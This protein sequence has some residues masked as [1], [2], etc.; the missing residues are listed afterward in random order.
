MSQQ[1]RSP[2]DSLPEEILEEIF[3]SYVQYNGTSRSPPQEPSK[4]PSP[5]VY[6]IGLGTPCTPILL[7]HVS[8]R[9]RAVSHSTPSLWSWIIISTPQPHEGDVE[10]FLLWLEKSKQALLT[11]TLTLGFRSSSPQP[12]SAR[13]LIVQAACA[14]ARRWRTAQ[15]WIEASDLEG[16][17]PLEFPKLREFAIVLQHAES[18]A[19]ERQF[20]SNLSTASNL[21]QARIDS[22]WSSP[23][24][25]P[26]LPWSTL[27]QVFLGQEASSPVMPPTGW[28]QMLQHCQHNLRNL[29]CQVIFE[30]DNWPTVP[31]PISLT[32]LT[33]LVFWVEGPSSFEALRCAALPALQSITIEVLHPTFLNP[34][35]EAMSDLGHRSQW[36]LKCLLFGFQR[37]YYPQLYVSMNAANCD[38]FTL[39]HFSSVA[40][41]VLSFPIAGKALEKL[42]FHKTARPFPMVQYLVLN[43]CD[44]ASEEAMFAMLHSRIYSVEHPTLTNVRIDDRAS[45]ET[46]LPDQ[47]PEIKFEFGRAEGLV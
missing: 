27:E 15:L 29:F 36:N 24:W 18:S 4:L 33:C 32:K 44:N 13:R 21:Q 28:V 35:W 10:I 37:K 47:F 11:L 34:A 2:I 25:V 45:V 16:F 9:W 40:H 23:S 38:T 6:T 17:P 26:N 14:H 8:A 12:C 39:P 7:G 42:T 1:D 41:L 43:Y 30:D 19:L 3:R 22:S 31:Q 5:R 20:V 46:S